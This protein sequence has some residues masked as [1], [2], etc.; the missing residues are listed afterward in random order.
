MKQSIPLLFQQRHVL[1]GGRMPIRVA[2][3]PQMDAFKAA[4]TS[5]IGFGICMFDEAEHGHH[6]FHIGTRVTVED[7]DTSALDGSLI[8]TVYG[9]E[10]FRI[11]ALEQDDSGVFSGEYDIIPQWPEVEIRNDQI[12][13]ADKL[14]QMFSK[15]PELNQLNLKKEFNNLSWLCQRWLEILPVPASEK[16]ALL[17]TPNCQDTYDYLMSIMQK[18]H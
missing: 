17:N 4:L 7:L 10:N 14:K 2:P 18:P 11:N 12:V 15:H 5:D 9:H 1:P 16:Q 3:G 6:F 8:V 13:L